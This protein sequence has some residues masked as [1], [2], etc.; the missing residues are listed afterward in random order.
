MNGPLTPFCAS[1]VPTSVRFPHL[2]R[3][4]YFCRPRNAKW[5]KR[6]WKL[7]LDSGT[8]IF[9][10]IMY[11]VVGSWKIGLHCTMKSFWCKFWQQNSWETERVSKLIHF[12]FQSEFSDV[13]SNVIEEEILQSDDMLAKIQLLGILLKRHGTEYNLEQ[14]SGRNPFSGII[15]TWSLFTAR[16]KRL[17][18]FLF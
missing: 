8:H 7:N 11:F 17:R 6:S 12:I 15:K 14:I 18:R 10:L 2:T 13:S 3:K 16:T 9:W 1:P 5:V 4:Y